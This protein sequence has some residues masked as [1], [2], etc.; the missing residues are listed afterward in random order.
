MVSVFV[1]F[2]FLEAHFRLHKDLT[3]E[4]LQII[5]DGKSAAQGQ[6]T[7]CENE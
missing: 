5:K 1:V 6:S 2:F 7:I 4:K 3:H